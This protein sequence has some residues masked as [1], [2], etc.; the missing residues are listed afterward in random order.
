MPANSTQN[1]INALMSGASGK[2][3]GF[4]PGAMGSGGALSDMVQLPVPAAAAGGVVPDDFGTYGHPFTTVRADLSGATNK[5]YPYRTAG[6]LFFQIN[7]STYICSASLIK[8]GIVVTAAHCVANYGASQF[9]SGWQFVPGYSNGVA[10]YGVWTAASARIMTSYYNGSDNC[11]VNGVICPNDVAVITLNAYSGGVVNYPGKKTGWLGYGWNGYG[12]TGTLT[13]ITQLGYPAGL[14][15]AQKMERNDSYGY[16]QSTYSNNTVIGSNMDGGSSGGPW[17][18]NLGRAPVLTGETNGGAAGNNI[19]VGV[20]SWG[21]V[22]KDPKEQ[23]ASPF[24]SG[25]I[26]ILVSAACTGTPAACQ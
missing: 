10:P 1:L 3:G 7:G 14:D 23:G 13:H 15:S 9:Y 16:T 5:M 12:F 2:G 18:V 26:T 22:S 11:Y 17:S 25:N 19:V 6:K 21:Y 20:T 4:S 8:R 24:T